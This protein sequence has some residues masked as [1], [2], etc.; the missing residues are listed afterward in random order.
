[1]RLLGG[2]STNVINQGRIAESL[3][4]A[5]EALELATAIGDPDLLILGHAF[6]GNSHFLMG[7]F[8]KALEHADNV[9]ALYDAEEHRHGADIFYHDVRR[10][11]GHPRI[12]PGIFRSISTWILGYAD[13]ALRL[14]DENDA[15]ARRRG[16]PFDLG[17]L[18]TIGVRDFDHRFTQACRRM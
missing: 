6:G 13:R 4:W 7:E 11:L 8:T 18:L 2:L 10:H 16:Q 14:N 15:N 3:P 9:V 17:W 5:Q 12:W 1:V